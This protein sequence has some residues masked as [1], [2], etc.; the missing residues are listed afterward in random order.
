MTFLFLVYFHL[1]SGHLCLS[2]H[3]CLLLWNTKKVV[4]IRLPDQTQTSFA[5]GAFKPQPKLKYKR[6]QCGFL[7]STSRSHWFQAYA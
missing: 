2:V 4:S 5:S 7:L 6:P 1:C 3:L